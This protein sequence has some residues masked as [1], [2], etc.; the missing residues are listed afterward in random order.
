MCFIIYC[1]VV[2]L[3]DVSGEVQGF[4]SKSL[5]AC[6]SY[7]FLRIIFILAFCQ[8][9]LFWDATMSFVPTLTDDVIMSKIWRRIENLTALFNNMRT[10]KF[11]SQP[12]NAFFATVN[13]MFGGTFQLPTTAER[14]V[15]K[16]NR[17]VQ[18]RQQSRK[19]GGA[20]EHL[21]NAFVG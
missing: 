11:K 8:S 7:V 10:L 1:F 12:T 2:Q 18:F 14:E 21:K 20:A 13:Q 17:R 16:S 3:Q 19:L 5:N 15:I 9:P 6:F 4:S